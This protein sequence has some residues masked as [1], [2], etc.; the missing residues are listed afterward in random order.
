MQSCEDLFDELV[1]LSTVFPYCFPAVLLTPAAVGRATAALASVE[2][3]LPPGSA[4][5]YRK[6]GLGGRNGMRS[7]VGEWGGRDGS[8]AGEVWS[9][10]CNWR[11]PHDQLLL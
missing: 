7:I 5:R 4:A 3:A 1:P 6:G 9:G 8:W 10:W 11:I 2:A